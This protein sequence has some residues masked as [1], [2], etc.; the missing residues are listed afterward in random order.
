LDLDG[1]VHHRIDLGDVRRLL[2]LEMAK[3]VYE[4]MTVLEQGFWSV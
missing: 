3:L 1:G 2:P 4:P